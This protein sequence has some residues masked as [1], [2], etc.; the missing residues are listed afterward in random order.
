MNTLFRVIALLF[1]FGC[2]RPDAL[3]KEEANRLIGE[4]EGAFGN[5]P[6]TVEI[7]SVRG[8]ETEGFSRHMDVQRPLKG[9]W[10]R[11]GTFFRLKLKEPGDHPY[12]GTFL[13][14]IDQKTETA[15]GVWFPDD[16]NILPVMHLSLRRKM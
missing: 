1:V 16:R 2:A 7:T 5:S 11:D 13:L 6:I 9:T 4:Y 15:Q 3:K 10:Q 14:R 8:E 12:D